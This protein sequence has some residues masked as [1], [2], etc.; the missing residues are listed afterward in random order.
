[1]IFTR[2]ELNEFK[3]QLEKE[4]RATESANDDS[5]VLDFIDQVA[6]WDD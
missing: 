1:M 2:T 4:F 6:D 5:E 3:H